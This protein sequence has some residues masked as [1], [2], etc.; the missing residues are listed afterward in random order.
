MYQNY[1]HDRY[2]VIKNISMPRDKK[3]TH[4]I[5]YKHF[6]SLKNSGLN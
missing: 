6:N 5:I 4:T 3:K 2:G 1:K